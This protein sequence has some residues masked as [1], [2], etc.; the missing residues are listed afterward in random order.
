M[1]FW[2]FSQKLFHFL[3]SSLS[4]PAHGWVGARATSLLTAHFALRNT[5][6]NSAEKKGSPSER[7]NGDKY[8]IFHK[9]VS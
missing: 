8:N 5:A 4:L 6:S 1:Q 3:G 2:S 9:Y 7:E